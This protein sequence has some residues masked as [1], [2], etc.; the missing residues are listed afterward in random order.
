MAPAATR[1]AMR[2]AMSALFEPESVA[3]I[4]AS[5]DM[6]KPGGRC[7]AFLKQFGYAG[8]VYPVNPRYEQIG[9]DACY[10]ALAAVPGAIDLVVLAVPAPAVPGY[11]REAAELGVRGAIVCSS[12]F[13]ETGAEGA[14]LEA[15][16]GAA[17]R[18]AGMALVGP[19]SLGVLDLSSNLAA[20]FS[21]ALHHDVELRPGPIAFVSQS[22]AMGAAILS[23]AQSEQIPT[24]RFVSTGNETVLSFPDY[25]EHLSAQDDVSVILGYIEGIDDGERLV[26][27]ARRARE[28]GTVVAVLKSG[29]SEAGREAALSHTG[30]MTGSAEAYEAAFRRAGILS[31]AS[32][33]ELLDTAVAVAAE[34]RPRGDRVGIVSMSGGAGVMMADRCD[35]VGLPV[36]PLSEATLARLRQLLPAYSGMR[37]PVDMGGV[38]SDPAAVEACARIVAEDPGVDILLVFMG[39]SP[40]LAGDIEARLAHVREAAGK[41]LA[42]AWLAGPPKGVARLRQLGVPVYEDPIRAVNAAAQMWAA[43][44]P[45]GSWTDRGARRR[46]SV[47][48]QA[49][50]EARATGGTVMTERAVKPLLSRYGIPVVAE[51]LARTADEA[52]RMA[53]E[54]AGPV[55]VKGEAAGLVHKSDH[56]AIRLDVDPPEA[57]RAFLA[58]T[59]ALR[60]AGIELARIAGAVVQPMAPPGV[61]LLVGSKYDDQFGPLVVVGLGGSDSEALGDVVVELAPVTVA[62]AGDML[63]RLRG[64]ALLDGFRGRPARDRAAAAE[65]I[66]RV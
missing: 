35:A 13:S 40:L 34:P 55:A 51:R 24:G 2:P 61:E 45:I 26:A 12:G 6:Q 64:N 62:Q 52:V 54:F 11:V 47:A 25:L 14:A 58:V 7:L 16:V 21:T 42:V 31:A 10:P 46:G 50:L 17:A 48:T 59:D 32:P 8:P 3:V 18:A 38:Y 20:T 15:E 9:G 56:G 29:T 60:E 49:L 41:P 23:L 57:G 22:G 4:G 66:S 63:D 43:S 44:R 39:L 37:N 65:A 27:C 53:A 5:P 30:S 1:T 28:R 36:P 19:N 33:R